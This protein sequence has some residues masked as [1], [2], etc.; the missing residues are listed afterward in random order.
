VSNIFYQ[1]KSKIYLFSFLWIYN[2]FYHY[3]THIHFIKCFNEKILL[4]TISANQIQKYLFP[5]FI[6]PKLFKFCIQLNTNPMEN[7]MV[8]KWNLSKNWI[9]FL[10]FSWKFVL[11]KLDF[12]CQLF[13][14]KIPCFHPNVVTNAWV[15]GEC[16]RWCDISNF[17][18]Q[19]QMM[20]CV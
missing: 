15:V 2:D 14:Y 6:I 13:L 5:T 11:F 9:Y 18:M 20:F 12:F 10:M 4:N 1:R 3:F 7:T 19:M 17:Y 16:Q 8:S